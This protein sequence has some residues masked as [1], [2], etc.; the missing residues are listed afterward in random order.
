MKAQSKPRYWQF[1]N[2]PVEAA[3]FDV[4]GKLSAPAEAKPNQQAARE[5]QS[6]FL[7]SAYSN[8]IQTERNGWK[9]GKLT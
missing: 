9:S 6:T 5:A 2:F 1:Q 7:F 3:F 8:A 4:P